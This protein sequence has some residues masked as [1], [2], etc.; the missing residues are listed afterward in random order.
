MGAPS[1]RPLALQFLGTS[2]ADACKA[3]LHAAEHRPGAAD[4]VWIDPITGHAEPYA[5]ALAALRHRAE[6]DAALVSFAK[7]IDV[8]EEAIVR[9]DGWSATAQPGGILWRSPDVSSKPRTRTEAAAL[10]LRRLHGGH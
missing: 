8:L 7:A 4:D 2:H 10:V 1:S 6:R 5:Q 3:L 9:A